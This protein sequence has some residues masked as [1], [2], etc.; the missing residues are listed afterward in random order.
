MCTCVCVA[1]G[2]APAASEL[3][4]GNILGSPTFSF[5]LLPAGVRE[6]P[7]RKGGASL[8]LREP[9]LPSRGP[10]GRLL[11]GAGR[12]DVVLGLE[13]PDLGSGRT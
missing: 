6:E 4:A 2:G 1:L 12:E 9:S 8:R 13:G 3:L 10:G 11:L 7:C 5:L